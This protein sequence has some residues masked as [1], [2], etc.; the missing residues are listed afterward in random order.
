VLVEIEVEGFSVPIAVVGT[1]MVRVMVVGC[2][3]TV[4]IS[5]GLVIVVATETVFVT[6]FGL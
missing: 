1:E 6:T 2:S 4:D 3:D 5:G